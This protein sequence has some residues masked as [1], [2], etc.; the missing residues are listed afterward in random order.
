MTKYFFVRPRFGY[1]ENV[2]DEMDY[3]N[4]DYRDTLVPLWNEL[5][6]RYYDPIAKEPWGNRRPISGSDGEYRDIDQREI[7]L[8]L[9]ASIIQLGKSKSYHSNYL[10]EKIDKMEKKMEK[11][12]RDLEERLNILEREK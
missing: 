4:I 5:Y 11:K 1:V 9:C 10:F 7:N 8:A 2:K 12:I 3:R 6:N